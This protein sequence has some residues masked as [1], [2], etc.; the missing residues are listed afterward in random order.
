MDCTEHFLKRSTEGKWQEEGQERWVLLDDLIVKL[1]H[2]EWLVNYLIKGL[3]ASHM[4]ILGKKNK[5]IIV[6][7]QYLFL[8]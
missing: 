1:Y 2:S 3:D 5:P 7:Q 6:I 8:G 4:D